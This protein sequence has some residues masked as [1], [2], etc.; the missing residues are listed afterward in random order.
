MRKLYRWFVYYVIDAQTE[1]DIIQPLATLLVQ[2]SFAI[3][4]VLRALL[5]SEHFFDAV[6]V[7]CIIKSPLDFTVGLHRQ[8][9]VV[10]PPASNPVVQY[11][12]W[13][14]LNELTYVQQQSLGDPPNVAG[15]A[16]YYQT[17]QYHE[18]WINAVTLPRRNQTTDQLIGGGYARGGAKIVIDP[19]ALVLALPAATASDCNLLIAEFVQLMAPIALTA[20][21]V[22]F[23][24]AALL[25][26]LPDFEWTVEWQQY[27]AVPTNTAKKAAVATKL[28]AMLR[29]LMGLAE[30]HLS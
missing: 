5:G 4:P 13:S 22:A 18:L 3:A 9:E 11:G 2:N 28:Q 26:G 30:Y 14:Y 6:N 23:L 27:A 1:T 19:V 20:T 10:F 8:M 24:K 25:P 21:Q 12:M 7:G 17:P 16:A 15:W 29:A